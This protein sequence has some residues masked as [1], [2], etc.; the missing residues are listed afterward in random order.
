MWRKLRLG[1]KNVLLVKSVHSNHSSHNSYF[2]NVAFTFTIVFTIV[3]SG[4]VLQCFE[5]W[6]LRVEIRIV[7]VINSIWKILEKNV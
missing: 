4:R 1:Q 3:F 5:L 2:L 7:Y 6:L